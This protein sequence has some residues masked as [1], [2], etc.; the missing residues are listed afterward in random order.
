MICFLRDENTSL[1]GIFNLVFRLYTLIR[2]RPDF[3]S[4]RIKKVILLFALR[5]TV[6]D[7]KQMMKVLIFLEIPWGIIGGSQDIRVQK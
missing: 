3:F 7:K 1:S 4:Y 6:S 5:S 2:I